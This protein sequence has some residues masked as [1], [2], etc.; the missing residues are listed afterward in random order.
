MK[1]NL[2][3]KAPLAIEMLNGLLENEEIKIKSIGFAVT[4]MKEDEV[5]E[6]KCTIVYTNKQ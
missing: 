6:A 5:K 4:E 3:G 1:I 2:Q